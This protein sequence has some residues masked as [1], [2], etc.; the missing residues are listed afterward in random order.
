MPVLPVIKA[1]IEPDEN[2]PCDSKLNG[3]IE[4]LKA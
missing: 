4:R 1:H 2:N 3:E